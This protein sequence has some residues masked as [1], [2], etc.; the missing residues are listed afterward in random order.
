MS[1]DTQILRHLARQ[2]AA[3]AADPV[4]D[5]R[6]KLWRRHNSMLGEY[7]FPIYVRRMA[8]DEMPQAKCL[9]EEPFYRRHEWNLRKVLF[10]AGLGD[11]FV[12]EPWWTVRAVHADPGNGVWGM[13][14]QRRYHPDGTKSY[15]WNPPIKKEDD[16][17]KLVPPLHRIDEEATERRRDKLQTAF[18]DALPVVVDRSPAC[19]RINVLLGR[20]RG[21]EQLMLDMVERPEWLQRLLALFR[22][23]VLH[24]H[25]RAEQAGHW[26]LHNHY[27]QSV[28]YADELDDPA[29]DGPAVERGDL[30]GYFEAQELTGVSPRMF[31]EF[32]V[33]YQMPL[34]RP[35]ALS[36]YGC[37]EDLTD[38]VDVLRQ[39]PNLRRIAVTP[40][41]DAPRCAEQIGTDYVISYRPSPADMVGYGWDPKRVRR[42]LR[43]D[44]EP[45]RGLHADICLKDTETVQGD[46]DRV[47]RWVRVV[48]EVTADL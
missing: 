42:I 39:I 29:A 2:Y 27:N 8:F 17:E 28:P 1:N 37:C 46:P 45:C 31:D 14:Y 35:F 32:M 5:R 25:E 21:I 36:A 24:C 16:I 43:R 48:R 30:W 22:D 20:L 44:L 11:D 4:Q 47:K 26:K 38:K 9:C 7:R 15:T 18:G 19:G 3:V 12:F 41:A 10:H 34:M 13:D 40:A 33:R 6:R 23:G